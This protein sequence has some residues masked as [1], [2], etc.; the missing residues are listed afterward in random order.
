[1]YGL[2]QEGMIAHTQLKRNLSH[3]D[4]KPCGYTP[5]LLGHKTR[6]TRLYLVVEYFGLKYTSNDNLQDILSDLKKL[7]YRWISKEISFVELL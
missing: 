7:Q 2:P 5:G 4:Y 6:Y 3:F 1:M